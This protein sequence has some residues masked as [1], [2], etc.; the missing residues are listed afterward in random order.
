MANTKKM[1]LLFFGAGVLGS[2]Y[3]ARLHEAGHDVTLLARGS[4]YQNLKK[5][6]VVLEAFDT[7]AITQTFVRVVDTMPTDEPF[8]ACIIL[9]RGNQLEEALNVLKQ[10]PH[11]D[12]YVSMVNA[13]TGTSSLVQAL[14]RDRVI[15]GHAN[16]GGE[17]DGHR[18]RYMISQEITL[19]ELD[20]ERTERLET[21]AG[22]FRSAN[23]PVVF[24]QDM[25]AWKRYHVALA[26]P[27]ANALYMSG[28]CN[29]RLSR[30][31]EALRLC[32]NGIREGFH[33]LRT[34]DFPVEPPKLRWILALPN[35]ILIPLFARILRLKVADIGMARHAR[36][37][38]DEMAALAAEF[39]ALI[40]TADVKTPALDALRPYADP[41]LPLDFEE[42]VAS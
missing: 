27:F 30:N 22:A 28:G 6:G 18:I 23:L 40:A 32:I 24:S 41:A 2:L 10:N 4:R 37:A 11:I 20:G 33:T 39:D 38:R 31:R 9:V 26:V 15:L 35:A 3:A 13:V 29:Y 42:E 12:Y 7:G 25:D 19:G 16:A 21:L 5:H 34:L 8:D 36:N 14:G 1:K 17:R